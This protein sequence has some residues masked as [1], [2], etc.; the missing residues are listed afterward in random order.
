MV[1]ETLAKKT[2][3]A[4][5]ANRHRAIA[6]WLV[7][8]CV[9]IFAMVVL[10]GVTR[11]TN[12]GLSMVQWRPLFGVL[13]PMGE[14]AWQA[15][16]AQYQQFPEYQKINTGMSLAEFKDIFWLEYL[17][18]LLGRVIGIAFIVPYLWFLIRGRVRGRLALHLGV[19]LVLGAL[20]GVLGWY[21]VKSGLVDRPDVSP[22]RLT[23]HLGLAVLI[24]GYIL[25]TAL[26]L[27]RAAPDDLPR[28][29][30]FARVGLPAIT[31]LVFL[32]LLSGGFVAGNDA[33]LAYNTFP[34]MEG[35]FVP[36]DIF[37][38]T[39]LWRNFF[40]NLPLVQ[41]DHR[42][43][44]ILT[45]LTILGLWAALLR[46]PV[47]R[48]RRRALNVLAAIA[49]IQAGLGISTLL[50]YVPVPLGAAHQAG[51]L[52]SLTA[53]LYAWRLVSPSR[54]ARPGFSGASA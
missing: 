23:A 4:P 17:H 10:G 53:A 45:V 34:L 14:A 50:L 6:L 18:R 9:L 32:T 25:W 3:A 41:L 31:G 33:G 44:A 2:H 52:L 27:I 54:L 28:L 7:A 12:S 21:M 29:P 1:D 8:V 5:A 37:R 26:G 51:A 13:P 20:Q 19:M 47:G 11:L 49:L 38:I 39:P 40:E 15:V 42:L 43:L 35:R 24:Y 22:Y 30:R 16:F 36:A 48:E 46:V